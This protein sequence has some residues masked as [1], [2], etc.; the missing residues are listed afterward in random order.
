MKKTQ[1][2]F[3]PDTMTVSALKDCAKSMRSLMQKYDQL[4]ELG[5]ESEEL[6]QELGLTVLQYADYY[7]VV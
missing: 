7:E 1:L 6:L 5:L 3:N 4:E 2:A